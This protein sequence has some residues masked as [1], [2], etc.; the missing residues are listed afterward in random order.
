MYVVGDARN[1]SMS[2]ASISRFFRVVQEK[3]KNPSRKVVDEVHTLP[4]YY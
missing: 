3:A 2:N 4:D 1:D